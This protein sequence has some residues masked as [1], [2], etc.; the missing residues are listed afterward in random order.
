MHCAYRPVPVPYWYRDELG[1]LVRTDKSNLVQYHI[2]LLGTLGMYQSDSGLVCSVQL[3]T[4][5][6]SLVQLGTLVY[7]VL[8]HLVQLDMYHTDS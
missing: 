7:H 6:Y 3:G 2:V 8:E 4:T 5:R 1:T